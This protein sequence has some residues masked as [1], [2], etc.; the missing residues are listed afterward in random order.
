[1]RS[2]RGQRRPRAGPTRARPG[3]RG[4]LLALAWSMGL[5][6]CPG[7]AAAGAGPVPPGGAPTL[8]LWLVDGMA[9]VGLEE[10][11]GPSTRIEVAAAR[12]EY[13]PFQVVIRAPAGGLS[14]VD[15]SV[16]DLVGP[17][18]ARIGA[19]NLALF[20]ERYVHL[21]RNST[22]FR[23]GYRPLPPG[24][25]AD[26]L[27]PFKLPDGSPNSTRVPFT[28]PAGRNQPVWVDLFVPRGADQS[29]PGTYS[30]TIT[31]TSD[32]GV[33][34]AQVSLTVWAFELPARPSLKSSFGINSRRMDDLAQ[35]DLLIAHK[36]MPATLTPGQVA[37]HGGR[38]ST[39][40]LP[41]Y[42]NNGS[43]LDGTAQGGKTMD[44]PP[45]A[46]AVAAKVDA[47]PRDLDLHQYVADEIAGFTAIFPTVRAWARAFHSTRARTL[48]TVPPT[49]A[50]L[51][52]NE[53]G[54]GRAAVD[55]WVM[56]P[57]QFRPEDPAFREAVSGG[58]EIWSYNTLVQDDYS[59]KWL[60]DYL[61]VG[62]RLQPG[63]ISQSLSLTG[64]LYWTVD[65]WA[66]TD[67]WDDPY[68]HQGGDRFAGDGTLIYPPRTPSFD[69][70]LA[71][72]RS[73]VPS[74]RLK[75]LRKGVEDFEYVQ[76][77]KE[78]GRGA[79]ALEVARSVG[80]DWRRWSKDTAAVAE[81]RMRL[82]RAL[83][84]LH[85]GADKFP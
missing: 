11:P 1:V 54:T 83:D 43:L 84:D 77:L 79:F 41:W 53:D 45:R 26:G 21:P 85:K 20:L 59:P 61:P 8:Q 60:I 4:L 33:A 12:G 24:W 62:W 51:H 39:T 82:G 55:L 70:G 29:P 16:S 23:T 38:V 42:S 18:G 50:L 47:Y 13:E 71:A 36:L 32:Q 9:R 34:T 5:A 3:A 69:T 44:P 56:L 48:V 14:S 64:L 72:T 31:V 2:G 76:L 80:A 66:N 7:G 49:A 40:G 58:A 73:G 46:A 68:F 10:R 57:A 35:Q 52:E 30:G 67:Y 37:R 27:I 25:Y 65:R 28:V 19:E 15:V 74:M 22:S 6:G 78:H 81:A 17:A 63:F 75:W